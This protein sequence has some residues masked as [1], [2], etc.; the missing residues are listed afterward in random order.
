MAG[1]LGSLRSVIGEV[2]GMRAAAATPAAS[3]AVS[4]ATSAVTRPAG[5]KRSGN[6]LASGQM[7]GK[8]VRMGNGYASPGAS[9]GSPA[10]GAVSAKGVLADWKGRI[11][12]EYGD[13]GWDIA[14]GIGK[15]AARGAVLGGAVGGT[16]EWSQGGSFWAGAKSGMF[17]GAVLN[18]GYRT[19]KT[20]TGATSR[21]PLAKQGA[22]RMAYDQMGPAVSNQVKTISRNQRGA[23]FAN[24]FMNQ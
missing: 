16:M 15:H 8:N 10:Q 2:S 18:S 3:A 17:D 20:A 14:K 21:N 5:L 22:V 1:R 23:T 6:L 4:G 12:N 24:K 19:L 11:N 7:G 9:A 13:N